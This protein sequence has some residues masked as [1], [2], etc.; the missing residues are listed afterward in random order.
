MLRASPQLVCELPPD[1]EVAPIGRNAEARHVGQPGRRQIPSVPVQAEALELDLEQ[2]A[3]ERRPAQVDRSAG[4]VAADGASAPA[5]HAELQLEI[6]DPAPV[7]A[8]KLRAEG[9]RAER[10]CGRNAVH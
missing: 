1:P 7:L 9:S 5:L 3:E 4:R 6:E 2:T 8:Q 10:M